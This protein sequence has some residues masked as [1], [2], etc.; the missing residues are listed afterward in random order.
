MKIYAQ[1]LQYTGDITGHINILL[2]LL[3]H[4]SEIGHTEGPQ[5]MKDL[6][7]DLSQS[8]ARKILICNI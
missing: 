7:K 3:L 5:Y 2:K 1:C 4:R 8:D 6:E